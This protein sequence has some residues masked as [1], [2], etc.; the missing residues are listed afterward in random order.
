MDFPKRSL[1]CGSVFRVQL[2]I[3]YRSNYNVGQRR[4]TLYRR[5]MKNE[6]LFRC[7]VMNKNTMIRH[8]V[9][10]YHPAICVYIYWRQKRNFTTLQL[11]CLMN[12]KTIFLWGYA[13]KWKDDEQPQLQLEYKVRWRCTRPPWPNKIS[14]KCHD[15]HPNNTSVPWVWCRWE[16]PSRV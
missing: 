4:Q 14:Q 12:W 5:K 7:H 3:M 11:K 9:L 15:W 1:R 16:L 13:K 10:K 6:C 2:Q 8:N